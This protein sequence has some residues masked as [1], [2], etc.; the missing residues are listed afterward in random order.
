MIVF[1]PHVTYRPLHPFSTTSVSLPTTR[2]ATKTCLTSCG[3]ALEATPSTMF[4]TLL[5]KTAPS[6]SHANAITGSEGNTSMTGPARSLTLSTETQF[7]SCSASAARSPEGASC[8]EEEPCSAASFCSCV[9]LRF[10]GLG[11]S[12]LKVRALGM[13]GCGFGVGDKCEVA[14]VEKRVPRWF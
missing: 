13:V 14:R 5:A 7:S 10:L 11:L 8:F 4:S 9:R 1:F 2:V 3:S 12:P 6:W